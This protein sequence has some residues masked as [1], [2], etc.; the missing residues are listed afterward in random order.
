MDDNSD[1]KSGGSSGSS[2]PTLQ[3]LT[4][5]LLASLHKDQERAGNKVYPSV[6]KGMYRGAWNQLPHHPLVYPDVNDTVRVELYTNGAPS[7]GNGTFGLQ[8]GGG[9]STMQLM[10]EDTTVDDI[11]RVRGLVFFSDGTDKNNM[12]YRKIDLKGYYFLTNGKMTLYG[13]TVVEYPKVVWDQALRLPHISERFLLPGPGGG[14]NEGGAV[15]GSQRMLAEDTASNCRFRIHFQLMSIGVDTAGS[16]SKDFS[17]RGS[18]PSFTPNSNYGEAVK[19]DGISSCLNCNDI[20]ALNVTATAI[21]DAK[22]ISSAATYAFIVILVTLAEI[23]LTNKQIAFT[24]TAA[25]TAKVSLVCVWWQVLL[26]FYLVLLHTIGGLIWDEVFQSFATA[27]F[28][29]MLLSLMFEVRYMLLIGKARMG[30]S[31]IRDDILAQRQEIAKLYT[32]CFFSLMAGVILIYQLSSLKNFFVFAAY[33]FW[34]PQIVSNVI[35][36]V[37]DPLLNSYLIGMSLTRLVIP[38]YV[39][40]YPYSVIRPVFNYDGDLAFGLT[41]MGWVALQVVVLLLQKRKHAR[42]FIPSKYLPHKYDYHRMLTSPRSAMYTAVSTSDSERGITG[43]DCVICMS[44]VPLG[45][46]SKYMISPCNHLFH[47][48]CL[49]QWMQVKMEC[50]TCRAILPPE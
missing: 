48:E 20:Q 14:S 5:S 11:K 42:F 46:T 19:I 9:L 47:T 35:R 37:K 40:I 8:L 13:N 29:K 38:F 24:S 2:E 22:M 10:Q 18:G 49:E 33:S 44:E 32:K 3:D 4:D 21:V 1:S 50:P 45:D 39:Y 36:D 12:F 25:T 41:I 23:V 15:D 17:L 27:S 43:K 16:D 26:D 30:E 28:F 7:R 31:S 34:V 6:I